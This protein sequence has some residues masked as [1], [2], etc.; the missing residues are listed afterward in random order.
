MVLKKGDKI[1]L[2][3]KFKNT[4]KPQPNFEGL[5]NIW[6]GK[7]VTVMDVYDGGKS[8]KIEEDGGSWWYGLD[9]VAREVK[10]ELELE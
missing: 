3:S 2:K 8:F 5:M 9:Y 1:I 10:K 6:Q 7:K 4:F